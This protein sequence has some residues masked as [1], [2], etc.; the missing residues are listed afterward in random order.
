MIPKRY[1]VKIPFVHSGKR[2]IVKIP[3]VHSGKRYFTG[4][5]IP[6]SELESIPIEVIEEKVYIQDYNDINLALTY[7]LIFHSTEFPFQQYHEEETREEMA[8]RLKCE[9]EKCCCN[10]SNLYLNSDS[11]MCNECNN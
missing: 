5:V 7:G 1:I 8:T 9:M 11:D 6:H 10:S 3:F 2:Y 4:K